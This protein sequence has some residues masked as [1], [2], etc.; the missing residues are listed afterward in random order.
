MA[1][2]PACG[3]PVSAE[4]DTRFCARCGKQLPPADAAPPAA[5]A[6][7]P[8]PPAAPPTM[9]AAPPAPPTM[10]AVPPAAPGPVPQQPPAPAGPPGV[11]PPGYGYP[12]PVPAG[13]SPA[14]LFLR[15]AMTG[16]WDTVAPVAL[17]PAAAVAALAVIIGVW[18]GIPSDH[19]P[20]GFGTRT[21][22][23][24]A[25][26]LTGIGGKLHFAITSSPDFGGGSDFGTSSDFDSGSGSDSYSGLGDSGSGDFA[27][28]VNR[29]VHSTTSV[30][31]LA[32]TVLWI[33][34]LAVLLRRTRP[35][36][37]AADGSGGAEAAVRVG[38]TAAAGALVLGL[39]ARPKI[40]AVRVDA[41]PVLVTLWAF[42]I[43]LA[44]ALVVLCRPA[45]ERWLATRPG[46]ATALR[47]LRTT[48]LALLAT[49]G[50][51]GV[52]VFVVAGA[53]W[54]DL[55]GWGVAAAALFSLNLGVSGLGLG[56]GA[57]GKISVG[58]GSYAHT[59][60]YGLGDLNHAWHGWAT[61][62]VV[63]GGV[64]CALVIGLLAVRRSHDRFEQFLVAGMFT[65]LFTLLAVFGGVSSDGAS[66]VSTVPVGGHET[67][68]SSVP[69]I[70][71]FGL[72]WSF[73]GV[74]VAPYVWRALGGSLPQRAIPL[75]VWAPPQAVPPQAAHPADPGAPA[76]PAQPGPSPTLHSAPT[77]V[78]PVQPAPPPPAPPAQPTVHD[79]GVVQPPRLN[80]PPDQR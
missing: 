70:L 55:T 39:I 1:F 58:T 62:L 25:L 19:P 47:A 67:L 72:L 9:P 64:V 4:A 20:I 41:G 53:H 37:T 60:T 15:R 71:L 54:S 56:W 78:A 77:Q 59:A 8:P 80:K 75:N 31:M 13:P 35:R 21:Q 28:S 17:V 73:G 24:L 52:V 42:A 48:V 32:V 63:L 74:F 40:S 27:D 33:V 46:T 57:P 23:A 61:V 49:I 16:R 22:A 30:I 34:L 6:P 36:L 69:E 29:T 3:N 43:S 38:L 12:P 2:C 79:L 18:S 26:L 50:L 14:M 66:V 44:T 5:Q 45:R 76:G 51:A 10:P 11:P 7:P 68:G 65:A